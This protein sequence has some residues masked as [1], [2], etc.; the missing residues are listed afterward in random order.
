MVALYV[1]L[2]VS[3]QMMRSSGSSMTS[4]D[5]SQWACSLVRPRSPFRILGAADSAIIYQRE[6]VTIMPGTCLPP[7]TGHRGLADNVL[8]T[9]KV[10]KM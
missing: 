1:H 5:I 3:V 10:H 7:T 6:A 4:G 9:S 2:S 8:L